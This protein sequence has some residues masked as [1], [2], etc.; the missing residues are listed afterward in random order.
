MREK[1]KKYRIL[2]GC[3]LSSFTLLVAVVFSS[4][5]ILAQGLFPFTNITCNSPW[6]GGSHDVDMGEIADPASISLPI[7]TVPINFDCDSLQFYEQAP[8]QWHAHGAACLA[9][10]VT[11]GSA[12]LRQLIHT[13][14]ASAP[15]LNFNFT[16]DGSATA[17]VG[18]G[19]GNGLAIPYRGWSSGFNATSTG[20]L[21]IGGQSNRLGV[22]IHTSQSATAFPSGVYEATFDWKLYAGTSLDENQSPPSEKDCAA[23]VGQGS[24]MQGK[25]TVRVQVKISCTLDMLTANVI[26]FG[27]LTHADLLSGFGPITRTI[28][29]ACNNNNDM[30]VTIGAGLHSGGNINNRHMELDGGSEL[31]RYSLTKPGGGEWGDAPTSASGYQIVG[32]LGTKQTIPIQARILPHSVM[33]PTGFYYDTVHVQLWN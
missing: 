29:I 2:C 11:S 6:G 3:L 20:S 30:Y 9:I 14:D 21:P 22:Y 25:I 17:A 19:L 15:P 26:D 12:A 33:V 10:D 13:T 18:N 1:M 5:P 32:S 24:I 8:G 7:Q 28:E 23:H 31:I 27:K 4:T 16:F